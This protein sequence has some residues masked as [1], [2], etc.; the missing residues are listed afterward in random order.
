MDLSVWLVSLL[1]WVQSPFMLGVII[2]LFFTGVPGPM[3]VVVVEQTLE[4]GLPAGASI[5]L[6]NTTGA[7]IALLLAA[8]PLMF[9]VHTLTDW[10][11]RNAS[12]AGMVLSVALL[13]LG[14]YMLRTPDGPAKP[15]PPKAGYVI[16][17]FFYSA[18][19]P[20][21]VLLNMGIISVLQA[22]H[23]LEKATDVLPLF[24]GYFTGTVTVWCGYLLAARYV[25]QGLNRATM[26]RLKNLM[27][28]FIIVFALGTLVFL[29][30]F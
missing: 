27:G 24:G 23:I 30:A 28:G 6:A 19:Q 29:L 12:L 2:T 9:G 4:K 14:V 5:S 18:L 3:N 25:R 13:A 22:N 21:N 1:A 26:Q 20:G 10:L 17:A 11:Q 7:L 16:W 8:L 15:Q